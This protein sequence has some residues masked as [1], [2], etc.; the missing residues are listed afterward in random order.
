MKNSLLLKVING[1]PRGNFDYNAALPEHI[2]T[3]NEQLEKEG[4]SLF[5]VDGDVCTTALVALAHNVLLNVD[6]IYGRHDGGAFDISAEEWG[7]YKVPWRHS[8]IIKQ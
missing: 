4:V 1:L 7:E 6:L 3:L 8:S 2:N 5:Y